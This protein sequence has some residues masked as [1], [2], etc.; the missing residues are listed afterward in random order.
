MRIVIYSVVL[1]QHQ[2]PI[3]DELWKLTNH[4]FTFVELT[5]LNDTKGGVENYSTRPYLLRAWENDEN[6]KIAMNLC[7]S[8][9]CCI[10]AGIEALPFEIERMKRNK[11]S[12]EMGERWFKKGVVSLLSPRLWKWVYTY[13]KENWRGKNIYKLCCSAYC[14][15]DH[16]K[17]GTFK[18]KCYK[19]GYFT[20]IPEQYSHITNSN[21]ENRT[22][23]IMWCGR[24]ISW[25]HP[26][27]PIKL[28]EKLIYYF[29][30]KNKKEYYSSFH[31]DMYGDGELRKQLKLMAKKSIASEHITFHGSV[32]NDDIHKSLRSHDI[33]IFT[34]D[35]GEGWGA[36]ANEAM[37]EGCV[38]IGYKEIGSVP[39]LIKDGINGFIFKS[40]NIE[41]LFQTVVQ[42][43]SLGKELS[44][45]AFSG[46]TSVRDFWSPQIAAQSLIILINN[47]KQGMDTPI[48]NG[49]CSKI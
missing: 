8:A 3:A 38:L 2:A 12:F 9:D 31:V 39:F 6:Y 19:W 36:V 13:Y 33:F 34:S 32:S 47:L 29:N 21:S 35:R 42:A 20:Q 5:N 40:P 16:Y 27:M 14:A 37:S 46:Y 22:F 41:D 49:P 10:F 24:F 23:R 45:I 43:I 44:K 18:N 4:Q 26:E 48:K 11:L 1:N 30:D 17:L 25:K 7:I 28:A 15:N